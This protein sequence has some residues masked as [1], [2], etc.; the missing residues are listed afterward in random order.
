MAYRAKDLV[1]SFPEGLPT[2]VLEYSQAG[3]FHLESL[4][5]SK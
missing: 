3:G 2:P 5:R 4:T 1:W